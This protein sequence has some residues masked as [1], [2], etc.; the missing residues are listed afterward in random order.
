ME[1]IEETFVPKGYTYYGNISEEL[2]INLELKDLPVLIKDSFEQE[3][4]NGPRGK[5][6]RMA[7]MDYDSIGTDIF[8]NIVE[9]PYQVRDSG[10]YTLLL[11]KS[12][13]GYVEYGKKIENW[14]Y[15]MHIKLV[16]DQNGYEFYEVIDFETHYNLHRNDTIL[17]QR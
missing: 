14:C 3:I 9:F 4:L 2:Q 12:F 16:S 7:D 1:K 17:W 8:M 11:I 5:F 10:N 13:D 15:A 6:I